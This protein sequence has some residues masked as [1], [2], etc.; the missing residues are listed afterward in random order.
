LYDPY[1]KVEDGEFVVFRPIGLFV[2]E[3][4]ELASN[5]ELKQ[6]YP[7]PFNPSTTIS[8][9]LPNASNVTLSVYNV[10]GQKV[11]SLING[12]SMS[13]GSYDFNFDAS[14]LSSGMYIYHIQAGAFSATKSMTLIK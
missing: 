11:A 8:F 12:Q 14:K 5:F 1:I 9:A 13:A 2:S 7:N 10:L 4:N 3:N 6:N